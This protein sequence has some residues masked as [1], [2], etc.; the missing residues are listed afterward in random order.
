[1]PIISIIGYQIFEFYNDLRSN[2][3]IPF[4]TFTNFIQSVRHWLIC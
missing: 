1:M 2:I 3:V 4:N